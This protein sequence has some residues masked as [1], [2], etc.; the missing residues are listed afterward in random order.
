MLLPSHGERL[1]Q[2]WTS[3]KVRD[4]IKLVLGTCLYASH[5]SSITRPAAPPANAIVSGIVIAAIAVGSLASFTIW[6]AGWLDL[7]VG[8][9]ILASPWLYGFQQ[10]ARSRS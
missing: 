9:W 2:P 8:L 7:I 6:R 4:V 1:V 5:G 3:A 10:S